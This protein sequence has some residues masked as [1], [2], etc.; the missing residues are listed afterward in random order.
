MLPAGR[1][2][3]L[4]FSGALFLCL[5]IFMVADRVYECNVPPFRGS[6]DDKIHFVFNMYDVSHDN[7]VSKQDLTTLLNQIPKGALNY[8]NRD[9]YY[10]HAPHSPVP[11]E[12]MINR[13]RSLSGSSNSMSEHGNGGDDASTPGTHTREQSREIK[14][15][16]SAAS[17]GSTQYGAAP[18]ILERSETSKDGPPSIAREG[19]GLSTASVNVPGV[20]GSITEF[21][22]EDVD[23]YTNHDMV[24]KAFAECDL[25]HEGRLTYEEFK[26]WVQRT[27]MIM[28]Y[29]ESI[30]PYNGPKDMHAHHHKRETLPHLKRIASR[31]SMGGRGKTVD[32]LA[33]EVFNHSTSTHGPPN[34]RTRALSM[35]MSGGTPR[36][37]SLSMQHLTLNMNN[38]QGS[39]PHSPMVPTPHTGTGQS[40]NGNGPPPGAL[41]RASSFGFPT[42]SNAAAAAHQEN[43]RFSVDMSGHGSTAGGPVATGGPASC[44][45]GEYNLNRLVASPSVCHDGLNEYDSEEMCRLYLIHAMEVTQ[46][47]SLRL[48]INSLLEE[49]PGGGV[50]SVDRNDSAEVQ[51]KI[52]MY[53]LFCVY[54][55]STAHVLQ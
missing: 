14:S 54:F 52:I 51:C 30:L 9:D 44:M 35:R 15:D 48:A 20:P 25:N 2:Q 37:H 1:R 34:T 32:E 18:G 11:S 8:E 21:D 33:G 7:T 16:A 12:I 42:P 45:P 4:Y 50:I 47:D 13:Q 55:L 31:M 3:C 41:S 23:F 40:G 17:G 36:G 29:I 43:N 49:T 46:N 22:Y 53:Q 5:C 28:E 38:V 19:S 24:E 26:M 10:H 39:A 27:P 6:M